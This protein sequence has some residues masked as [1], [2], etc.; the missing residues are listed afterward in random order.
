MLFVDQAGAD[1]EAPAPQRARQT[2]Q[3]R[4][5]GERTE[6]TPPWGLPPGVSRGAP[7]STEQGA[8]PCNGAGPPAAASVGDAHKVPG[9]GPGGGRGRW[10]G[11]VIMSPG[12]PCRSRRGGSQ[13]H[14]G[15]GMRARAPVAGPAPLAGALGPRARP[16][17][18]RPRP[19]FSFLRRQLATARP[20]PG[21]RRA[22]AALFRDRTFSATF[23]LPPPSGARSFLGRKLAKARPPSGPSQACSWHLECS[24]ACASPRARGRRGGGR[25]RGANLSRPCPGRWRHPCRPF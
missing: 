14:P 15:T 17:P 13:G 8:L 12:S 1:I 3:T 6:E 20:R 18:A 22:V 4:P 23:E 25:H 7:G 10:R 19:F 16:R 9:K 24:E 21:R 2:R 5:E 11:R